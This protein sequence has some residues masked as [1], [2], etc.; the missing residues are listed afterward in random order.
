MFK[1]II[2][3][4]AI[5]IFPVDSPSYAAAPRGSFVSAGIQQLTQN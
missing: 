3:P 1:T 2:G 5:T 4:N